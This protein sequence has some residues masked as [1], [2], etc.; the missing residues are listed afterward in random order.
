SANAIANG[1]SGSNV[2]VSVNGASEARPASTVTAINVIGTGTTSLAVG[3][4]SSTWALSSGTAGTVTA[5]GLPSIT[6]SNVSSISASGANNTLGGPAGDATW[7]VTGQNSGS[8]AGLGFSGFQN[9]TGAAN[10]R[11]PLLAP[12]GGAPPG[13]TQG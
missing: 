3:A 2:T 8:V 1:S 6:F 10:N 7:T 13:E 5:A 12:T 4:T 9:L 11:A